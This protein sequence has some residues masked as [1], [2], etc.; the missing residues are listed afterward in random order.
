MRRRGALGFALIGAV[1]VG[2]PTWA[3]ADEVEMRWSLTPFAQYTWTDQDEDDDDVTG[4]FDQYEFT[5][6]KSSSFP[7]EIGLRDASLDLFSEGET[8]LLQFRL[9]SPTSNLGV[10][11]NQ[12]DDPFFNQRA[13]LLGRYGGFALDLGYHRIRTLS[14]MVF[15]AAFAGAEVGGLWE[16][17][18]CVTC[19][20][21]KGLIRSC[22]RGGVVLRCGTPE[23]GICDR[24]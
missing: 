16:V 18:V 10:S 24:P 13:L 15:Q 23:E 11:G 1:L 20:G 9:E 3:A 4:F 2:A 8:P 6:N 21:P 17:S 22:K 19:L 12:A 14:V 5:P 7:L